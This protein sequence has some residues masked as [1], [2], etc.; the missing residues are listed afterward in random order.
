VTNFELLVFRS[1]GVPDILREEN[2]LQAAAW[3]L[4]KR[5]SIPIT[6]VGGRENA[7]LR[8]DAENVIKSVI[9]LG[10]EGALDLHVGQFGVPPED[11]VSMVTHRMDGPASDSDRASSLVKH[12]IGAIREFL[13]EHPFIDPSGLPTS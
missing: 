12:L 13:D 5:S 6:I 2:R 1:L 9:K 3:K 4:A 10:E 11:V 7:E 8:A